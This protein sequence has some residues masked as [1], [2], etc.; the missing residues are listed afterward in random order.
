MI[1]WIVDR[2]IVKVHGDVFR[3]AA[4]PLLFS[5]LVGS[6]SQLAVVVLLTVLSAIIGELYTGT[7]LKGVI[8]LRRTRRKGDEIRELD[9]FKASKTM[10][11]PLVLDYLR[12]LIHRMSNFLVSTRLF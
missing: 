3:P 7:I 5:A 11:S 4:S 6:G 12:I 2:L 9:G 8:R 1:G 10:S